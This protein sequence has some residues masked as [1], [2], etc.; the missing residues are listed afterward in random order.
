MSFL[1]SLL[2]SHGPNYLSKFFLL[3]IHKTAPVDLSAI[4]AG[5]ISLA[6]SCHHLPLILYFQHWFL[7]IFITKQRFLPPGECITEGGEKCVFPFRY[8]GILYYECT[9]AGGYSKPWCTT[10]TNW[11]YCGSCDSGEGQLLFQ[12][13]LPWAGSRLGEICAVIANFWPA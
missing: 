4:A 1:N 6:L 7:A 3:R 12:S 5:E 8:K 9:T 2:H 11:D 13:K 10:K